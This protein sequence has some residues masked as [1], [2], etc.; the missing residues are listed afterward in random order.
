[1]RKLPWVTAM[2]VGLLF[3]QTASASGATTSGS[4]D[5]TF[6]GNGVAYLAQS[7]DAVVVQADGKIVVVGAGRT[8]AGRGVFAVTRFN[9]DGT[10]DRSFSGDGPTANSV[11]MRSGDLIRDI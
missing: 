1:M 8:P 2:A 7:A 9:H 10:L 5:R 3:L 4:L 6:S 11:A